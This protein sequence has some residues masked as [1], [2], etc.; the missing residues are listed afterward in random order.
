MAL[1]KKGIF[2]WVGGG[3]KLKDYKAYSLGVKVD[4]LGL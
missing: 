1:E 3:F 2:G 4:V